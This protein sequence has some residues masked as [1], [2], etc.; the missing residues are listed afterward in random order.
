MRGPSKG[1]VG[2]YPL[3]TLTVRV[4]I[5]SQFYKDG[6]GVQ[7]AGAR[8]F[9]EI[10]LDLKS[11]SVQARFGQVWICY[12]SDRK[13]AYLASE[14]GGTSLSVD[15][16]AAF[17]KEGSARDTGINNAV[18]KTLDKPRYSG[19]ASKEPQGLANTISSMAAKQVTG[20]VVGVDG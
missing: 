10:T 1:M 8:A 12:T 9:R 11:P 15:D 14:K 7:R 17:I 2:G 5:G 6:N 3:R 18:M 4:P 19:I 20:S 13:S 16:F